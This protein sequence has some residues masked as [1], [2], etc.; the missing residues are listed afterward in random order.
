MPIL[1]LFSIL[2][3]LLLSAP[4]REGLRNGTDASGVQTEAFYTLLT[5]ADNELYDAKYKNYPKSDM[6]L[7][8]MYFNNATKILSELS[9]G[10]S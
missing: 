8:F 4:P 10:K 2:F 6:I 3:L 9:L 1:L 7:D 5:T